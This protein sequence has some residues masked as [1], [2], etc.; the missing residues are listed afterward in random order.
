MKNAVKESVMQLVDKEQASLKG[1]KD[2]YGKLAGL[3]REFCDELDLLVRRLIDMKE[4][5][6]ECDVCR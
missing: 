2:S 5:K 4:L 6:G 3:R 1:Q